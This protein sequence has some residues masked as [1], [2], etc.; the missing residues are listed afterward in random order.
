M[1][2]KGAPLRIQSPVARVWMVAGLMFGFA[3]KSKSPSH[4]SL[5]KFAAFTLR[6]DERWSRSSHSANNSSARNP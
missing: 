2:H 6:M 5:G 3:S 4:L 1:R